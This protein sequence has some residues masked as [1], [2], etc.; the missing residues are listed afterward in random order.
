MGRVP[1]Q[2]AGRTKIWN[3]SAGGP[4]SRPAAGDSDSDTEKA[5]VVAGR[6]SHRGGLGRPTVTVSEHAILTVRWQCRGGFGALT[7]STVTLATA[8]ELAPCQ[9]DSESDSDGAVART[10]ATVA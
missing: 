1:A 7:R 8:A 4:A 3:L 10:A 5:T 2:S 6:P 9:P